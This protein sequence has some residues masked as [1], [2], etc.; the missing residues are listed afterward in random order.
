MK[1]YALTDVGRVRHTNQDYLFASD[2]PIG[3]LPNLYIVADGMGGHNAGDYASSHA[4][5]I[6]V[7]L[8]CRRGDRYRAW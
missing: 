1:S 2:E 8:C 6:L 5:Q 3:N 7:P 4:V